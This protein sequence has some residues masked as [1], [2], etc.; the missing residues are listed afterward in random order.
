MQRSTMIVLRKPEAPLPPEAKER[1][2]PSGHW[3]RWRS[4]GAALSVLL[5]VVL[6]AVFTVVVPVLSRPAAPEKD[7]AIPV[8]VVQRPPE[9]K[10]DE[11]T[12]KKEPEEKKPELAKKIPEPPKLELPKAN[13]AP[14]PVRPEPPKAESPPAT[15]A[16]KITPPPP[17]APPPP[18][19][20]PSPPAA[21]PPAFPPEPAPHEPASPPPPPTLPPEARLPPAPPPIPQPPQAQPGTKVDADDDAVPPLPKKGLG[22]WVLEPVTVNLG[23]KCGLARLTGVIELKEEIGEGRYRGTMRTRIGWSACPPEGAL[24]NVELRIKGSEVEMIGSGFVDRGV[25]R[26]NTMLLEDAYGRSVWKKR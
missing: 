19:A 2:L 15:P 21:S 9:T 17:P 8:E 16:A 4:G 11:K 14:E 12:E 5:H 25:I 23:H 20:A 26:A 24:R 13:A 3:R 7:T 22:Y 10:A 18:K 6:L 1:V